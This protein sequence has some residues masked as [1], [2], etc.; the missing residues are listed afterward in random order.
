[1]DN[2]SEIKL[3]FEVAIDG[4]NW[5]LLGQFSLERTEEVVQHPSLVNKVLA[6]R[7]G[8]DVVFS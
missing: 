4:L 8:D 6:D 5:I 7:L 3:V 1:M 2:F